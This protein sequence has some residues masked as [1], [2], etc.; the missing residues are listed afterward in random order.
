MTTRSMLHRRD[1][2]FGAV[3]A[4]ALTTLLR[5]VR[6]LA[7]AIAPLTEHRYARANYIP[8]APERAVVGS[9]KV[10]RG[11]VVSSE[12]GEAIPNAKVEYYLNTTPNGGDRGEQD[13]TNRGFVMAD[14]EGRF[15][16][17]SDPPQRVWSSAEPH[18]HTR[19]TADGHEE[20]YYRHVTPSEPSEDDIRIVLVGAQA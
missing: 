17:E 9:G 6:A 7:Q 15:T 8:D 2:L 11:T 5:P 1:F 4:T 13:P 19:A 3:A 16:F 14:A 12:T 20:F 18:V 10:I